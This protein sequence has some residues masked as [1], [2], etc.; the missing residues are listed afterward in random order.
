MSARTAELDKFFPLPSAAGPSP[1]APARLPGITRA[2]SD[3]LVKALKD[4]HV[5]HHAYFNDRGFHKY[6]RRSFFPDVK[7]LT[8]TH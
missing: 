4:N 8:Y 7:Y 1:S 5:N 2:A 3:A 6:V